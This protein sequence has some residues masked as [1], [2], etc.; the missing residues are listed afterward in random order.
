M[1]MYNLLEYTD[2]Y[3]MRS[4]SLWNYHRNEVNDDTNENDAAGSFGSI[5]IRQK[6]VS[7]LSVR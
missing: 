7:L 1:P 6:Q 2:N 4:R 5:N 3:S